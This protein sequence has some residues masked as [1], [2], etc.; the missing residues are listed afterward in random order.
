MDDSRPLRVVRAAGR[1]AAIAVGYATLG[2][3]ALIGFEVVAR[4]VFD[5]SLQGVDEIGGYVLAAV[6]T[7]G[8][9]YALLLHA[10]TRVD[11]FLQL[12]PKRWHGALHL[13]SILSLTGFAGFMTWTGAG[14][15]IDSID[16]ASVS[17]T[18]LETP[19]WIPQ[20]IWV[21]GL[22][23]FTLMGV[24]MSVRAASLLITAPE[25]LAQEIEASPQRAE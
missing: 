5:F 19:M 21:A 17:T 22:T 6:A 2:L 16:Y 4:K 23:A 20:A 25:R 12:M 11:I 7:F 24:V 14:T 10:H 3:A 9:T 13:L 18:P 8:F 15:L 1:Y